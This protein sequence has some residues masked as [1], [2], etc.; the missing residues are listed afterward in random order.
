LPIVIGEAL[1]Q[2]R[3]ARTITENNTTC[4]DAL[5]RN[6]TRA[7]QKPIQQAMSTIF[8]SRISIGDQ[9]EW[10]KQMWKFRGIGAV[11]LGLVVLPQVGV[12]GYVDNYASWKKMSRAS[13]LG[14]AS[15]LFDGAVYFIGG[16]DDNSTAI[17]RGLHTCAGELKS[18]NEMIADA[19]SKYYL[20]DAKKW[21][22]AATVAFSDVIIGRACLDH[23]NRARTDLGLDPWLPWPQQ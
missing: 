11:L 19:I 10:G 23:V 20:D 18:N 17:S 7:G 21:S 15:A 3:D 16:S 12:A 1:A 6:P 14:Y 4:S 22:S 13:Q 2:R 8:A 9:P 5:N